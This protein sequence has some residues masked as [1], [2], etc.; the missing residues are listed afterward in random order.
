MELTYLKFVY[1]GLC[2]P[3]RGKLIEDL[4]QAQFDL[5]VKVLSLLSSVRDFRH[6]LMPSNLREVFD[7][8]AKF[9]LSKV[10]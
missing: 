5:L 1:Y 8:V 6:L 7:H 2:V 3:G 9:I 4:S 10:P